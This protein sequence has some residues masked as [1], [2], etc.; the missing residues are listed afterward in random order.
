MLKAFQDAAAG[1]IA[2]FEG[3]VAGFMGDGV[4]AYFGGPVGRMRTRRSGQSGRRW[5]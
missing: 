2:R 3:H 5:P 4:L 1:E